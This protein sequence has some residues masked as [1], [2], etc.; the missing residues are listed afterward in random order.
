MQLTHSLKAPGFNPWTYEVISWFQAFA[1]KFK[2]VPLHGGAGVGG[3]GGGGGAGGAGGVV[4]GAE[5]DSAGGGLSYELANEC[6]HHGHII[7][8]Y[9]AV[10][11]DFIVVGDLMK[12]ISLLIYKP[13]EGAIEER[14]RDFNANWMTAVDILDDD[15]YLGE[16]ESS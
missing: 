4:G 15:T 13:D 10:R 1:F 7:A 2:L 14:A 16:V 11:G 5:G 8:L 6:S 12:S 9:V 3:G